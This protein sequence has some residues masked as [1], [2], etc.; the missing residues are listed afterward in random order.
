MDWG[1][2]ISIFVQY[3]A[4]MQTNLHLTIDT[5]QLTNLQLTTST[6]NF[7]LQLFVFSKLVSKTFCHFS[8]QITA[9]FVFCM[10][11]PKYFLCR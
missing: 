6:Y 5:L 9:I 10:D 4:A 8:E 3:M 2:G 11:Y 1:G 7:N